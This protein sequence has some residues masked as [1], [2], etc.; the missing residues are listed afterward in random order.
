VSV[1]RAARRISSGA[2]QL[3]VYVTVIEA[4]AVSPAPSVAFAVIVF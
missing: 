1:P 3:G 2:F 4:A